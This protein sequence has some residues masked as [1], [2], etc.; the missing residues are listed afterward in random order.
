MD[1]DF[2]NL[3]LTWGVVISER[4]I[5][6]QYLQTLAHRKKLK[7]VALDDAVVNWKFVVPRAQ[8]CPS[9]EPTP[10]WRG[11]TFSISEADMGV[12]IP[13][14]AVDSGFNRLRACDAL[15]AAS[16]SATSF[17]TSPTYSPDMSIESSGQAVLS[18]KISNSG[19]SHFRFPFPLSS[20]R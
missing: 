20:T 12:G 7:S 18:A 9:L 11:T 13:E 17:N 4:A 19:I 14:V 16:Q 2:N 1:L 3:M 15:L 10:F 5:F 6:L 8:F